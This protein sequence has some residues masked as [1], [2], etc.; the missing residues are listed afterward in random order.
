MNKRGIN[1]APP[2]KIRYSCIFFTQCDPTRIG[3]CVTSGMHG[4]AAGNRRQSFGIGILKKHPFPCKT[5]QVLE[6][7][8]W[9]IAGP[10]GAALILG[11]KPNT[12]RARMEKLGIKKVITAA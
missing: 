7:S 11:L 6:L 8:N 9:K 2:A 1:G 10:G 3:K 5:I 4:P 12:L